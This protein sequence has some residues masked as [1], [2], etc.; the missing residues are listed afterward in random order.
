MLHEWSL[1]SKREPPKESTVPEDRLRIDY[2]LAMAEGVGAGNGL[3]ADM[4]A[5]E[6]G[7][8]AAGLANVLRRVQSGELGFWKLPENM[9]QVAACDRVVE[10]LGDQVDDVLVL[11]IGGSSLGARAAVYALSNP[12]ASIGLAPGRRLHFPDNSDAW[13]FQ[14]LL[15]RLDPR[16]TLALVISKSGG[17]VET[18]AQMLCV[19]AW[20]EQHLGTGSLRRHMVAITDPEKGSLRAFARQHSLWRSRATWAGAS[21]C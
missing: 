2:A 15:A 14:A 5:A 1:Q 9:A 18:A 11:G 21:A 17:T 12:L 3:S 13:L 6:Q 7:V 4:L 20:F 10:A 16:R 19:Q 8:F